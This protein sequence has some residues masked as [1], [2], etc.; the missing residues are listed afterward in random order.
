MITI[1]TIIG[2]PWGRAAIIACKEK[3]V[4]YRIDAL[5]AGRHRTPE[6]LSRH[7]YGKVPAIDD[8]GFVLYETPVIVSYI[9]QVGAGP[10][11]TPED[12]KAHARMMQLFCVVECYLFSQSGAIPLAFNRVVAPGLGLPVDEAAVQA[13]LPG[14]RKAIEVMASFLPDGAPYMAGASFSLADIV[15]GTHLDM[16]S[17]CPEGAEMMQ[18][19]PLPAWL[20]R[21]RA[22][23]SFASTTWAELAKAA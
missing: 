2:S 16:I 20:A 19:T 18:E 10:S 15:A 1:H 12:P 13:S 21:L 8:D 5:T 11:L 9:D 3:H 6:Q 4:S 23:P 7:P 17:E 14:A 22:R